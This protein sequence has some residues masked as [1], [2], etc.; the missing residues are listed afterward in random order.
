VH[1]TVTGKIQLTVQQRY[2]G[3]DPNLCSDAGE[4]V[5][6]DARLT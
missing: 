5:W 3:P 4:L 2:L 6:G 1:V